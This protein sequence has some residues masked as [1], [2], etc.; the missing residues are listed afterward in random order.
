MTL[1]LTELQLGRNRRSFMICTGLDFRI[2]N[3]VDSTAIM[4]RVGEFVRGGMLAG[5][6]LALVTDGNVVRVWDDAQKQEVSILQ[7]KNEFG[8]VQRILISKRVIAVINETGIILY[9][10]SNLSIIG[11]AKLSRGMSEVCDIDSESTVLVRPGRAE[12][13]LHVEPILNEKAAEGV[14]ELRAHQH[15]LRIARLSDDGKLV[16]TASIRGTLVRVFNVAT[17]NKI[18][19]FRCGNTADDIHCIE[20]DST[21]TLLLVAC[22]RIV[23]VF[24]ISNA[25]RVSDTEKVPEI[26]DPS[27]PPELV[28]ST[29]GTKPRHAQLDN[30]RSLMR[31]IPLVPSYFSSTWSARQYNLDQHSDIKF[32]GG[33]VC[34]FTDDSSHIAVLTKSGTRLMFPF[35]NTGQLAPADAKP[36]VSRYA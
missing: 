7:G 10:M 6:N 18:A 5:S 34:G 15:A 2:Q 20:F 8:P 4:Y 12:G 26:A 3:L 16:A 28:T 19:E 9:S 11:H 13:V 30:T 17:S 14:Y 36:S 21:G 31:Y 1:R 27:D 32:D 25:Q 35:L 24:S 22:G 29:L 33:F 23:H